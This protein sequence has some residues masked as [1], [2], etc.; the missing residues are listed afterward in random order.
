MGC[1]LTTKRSQLFDRSCVLILVAAPDDHGPSG[2]DDSLGHPKA[3]AS[4]P[5]GYHKGLTTEVDHT[6]MIL[7]GSLAHHFDAE[8]ITS[9]V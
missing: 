2:L 8:L 5:A 7:P 6:R 1:R 3:D 4:V 9:M